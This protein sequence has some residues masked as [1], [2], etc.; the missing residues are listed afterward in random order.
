ME[1]IDL[2]RVDS[3]QPAFGALIIDH[4]ADGDGEGMIQLPRGRVPDAWLLQGRQDPFALVP[5][6]LHRNCGHV[7]EQAAARVLPGHVIQVASEGA[8]KPA[9]GDCLL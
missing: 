3:Q 7:Q 8:S 1:L 2:V 5:L 9:K 6:V 4:D